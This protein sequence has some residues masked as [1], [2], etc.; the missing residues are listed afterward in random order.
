[1]E[2]EDDWVVGIKLSYDDYLICFYCCCL[3]YLALY[4]VLEIPVS[5]FD[6]NSYV[7]LAWVVIP[8]GIFTGLE[9]PF[10]DRYVSYC[11]K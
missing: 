1:M 10:E 2:S 5:L 6:V 7:S 11:C 8:F 3:S 9:G 4:K